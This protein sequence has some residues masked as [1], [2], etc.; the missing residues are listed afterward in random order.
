MKAEQG[1]GQWSE[2]LHT[3]LCLPVRMCL[4]SVW[5]GEC[6]VVGGV[7]ERVG[8]QA[9]AEELLRSTMLPLASEAGQ[10]WAWLPPILA[11][12][13]VEVSIVCIFFW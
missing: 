3:R 13:C 11:G 12:R 2:R 5:L 1:D 8:R 7:C 9:K 10:I 4:V 6:G